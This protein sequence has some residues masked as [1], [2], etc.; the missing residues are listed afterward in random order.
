MVF[1]RDHMT[2]EAPRTLALD[3]SYPCPVCQLGNIE[4]LVL[5]NAFSCELCQHIFSVDLAQQQVKVIDIPQAITWRWNGQNW[6]VA[7]RASGEVSSFVALAASLLILVPASLVWLAGFLFP[8]LTP[9]SQLSFSTIWAIA[10]LIAHLGLVLWLVGEYYQIPFY[11]T[12]KVRLFR[13][14]LSARH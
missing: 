6:Q 12:T 4:A 3:N 14:R 13:Q 2:N 8:P 10:T 7:N 9:S 1:I 11:I 5:T